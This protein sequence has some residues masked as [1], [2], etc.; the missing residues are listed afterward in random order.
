[1]KKILIA[2][3]LLSADFSRLAEE[4]RE[5]EAAGCDA[6][7]IDVMDGQFVPNL[8]I[9]PLVIKA[10][11]K[12]TKLPLDVHLMIDQPIR[13]IS[14]F[15][16]AGADWITIHVEAEK[17]IRTVL[18]QIK[19]QG[20]KAGLSIKP[21]TSL[22]AIESYLPELDLVLIMTVEPG[23]GGQSFMPEPVA[24]IKALRSHFKKLISVDGGI[25]L[26]TAPQVLD[27]GADVLVAGSAIF[28][29]P[30]RTKAI[31]ELREVTQK[32]F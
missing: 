14:D 27:A 18:H 30:D 2:P 17:D 23:F 19:K 25:D 10:V 16:K 8:T 5:V 29:R 32:Y 15:Q 13:Y 3:S 31:Q 4:I 28:G 12:V 9:G 11:R 7:H 22:D 20:T 6:I 26:K 24:K 21:G 1:M